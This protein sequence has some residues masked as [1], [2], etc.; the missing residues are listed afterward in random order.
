MLNSTMAQMS[1]KRGIKK[2]GQVA[3]EAII[4]EFQQLDDKRILEPKWQL[5]L[6]HKKSEKAFEQL[7]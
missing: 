4:S 5:T 1:A 7:P 3:I 2:H 6:I